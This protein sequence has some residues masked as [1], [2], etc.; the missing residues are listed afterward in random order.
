MRRSPVRTMVFA[1]VLT[2]PWSGCFF[3]PGGGA[4]GGGAVCTA[5]S[6]TACL[7]A[8]GTS[9]QR[10]CNATGTVLSACAQPCACD[11]GA[12]GTR[13]CGVAG[14]ACVCGGASSCAP[15]QTQVCA[16][17]NG[18]AGTQTCALDGTGWGACLGCGAGS[19]SRTVGQACATSTDCCASG[20]QLGLCVDFGASGQVCST[21][22]VNDAQCASGCCSLLGDGSRACGPAGSC[23]GGA[24]SRG[25][26]QSCAGDADC[27]VDGATGRRAVCT[28]YG[29]VATCWPSCATN[30]ECATGCCA[31]RTDGVRTCAPPSYCG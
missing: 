20:G 13:A 26:G 30:A 17:S 24:C 23:V 2:A 14:A 25:V 27:C 21:R 8:D 3:P 18:G 15:G 11:T 4:S 16:C 10:T 6:S 7:C 19:C 1:L 28:G 22:C 31:T 9:G 29:G 12:T 5:N